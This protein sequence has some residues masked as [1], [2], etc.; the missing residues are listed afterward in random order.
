MNFILD[1]IVKY[2]TGL[3]IINFIYYYDFNEVTIILLAY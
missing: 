1:Q 2:Y 3:A